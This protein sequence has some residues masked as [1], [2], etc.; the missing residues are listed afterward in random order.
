MIIYQITNE[1]NG[2][3]YIGKTT[4]TP[5]ERLK[6]HSYESRYR[7]T[8]SFLHKSMR[9]H[10][11]EN[12]TISIIESEIPETNL[13]ERERYWIQTLKPHYNLTEGGEGGDTS[14]SPKY[15]ES[16]KTRKKPWNGYATYGML[17]KKFPEG[18]KRKV[19]KKNSYPIMVEGMFFPSIKAAEEYYRIIG[20]PKSVRKRV[21]SPLHPDWYRIRPKRSCPR[22]QSP[23]L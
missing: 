3:F 7:R 13:D 21:D 23:S 9:K 22:S 1:I 10:G 8:G 18:A 11:V 20:T 16:L 5:E 4:K 6:C 2:K 19:G 14:K 15:I 12:F 17:G